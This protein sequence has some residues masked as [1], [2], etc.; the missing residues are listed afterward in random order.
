MAVRTVSYAGAMDIM[1]EII[2]NGGADFCPENSLE[3]DSPGAEASACIITDD[4][5][6]YGR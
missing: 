5:I 1:D 4:I 6:F 2:F 3:A